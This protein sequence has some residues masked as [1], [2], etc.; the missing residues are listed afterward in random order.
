MLVS[1]VNF[2]AVRRIRAKLLNWLVY[3]WATWFPLYSD[4]SHKIFSLFTL[5]NAI[6]LLHLFFFLDLYIKGKDNS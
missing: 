5:I 6:L 2:D 1:T 4:M 3:L